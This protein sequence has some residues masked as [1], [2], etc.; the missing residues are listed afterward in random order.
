MQKAGNHSFFT[1]ISCLFRIGII[2]SKRRITKHQAPL[3][4]LN[5]PYLT[6]SFTL[7]PPTFTIYTPDEAKV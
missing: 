7:F 1:A 3:S 2:T 4:R 5:V 6:V